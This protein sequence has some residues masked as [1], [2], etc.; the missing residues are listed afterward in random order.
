MFTSLLII[1]LQVYDYVLDHLC[2]TASVAASEAAVAATGAPLPGASWRQMEQEKLSRQNAHLMSE[3]GV[4][5]A[6]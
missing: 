5:L 2:G 1:R 6:A 4:V 3:G